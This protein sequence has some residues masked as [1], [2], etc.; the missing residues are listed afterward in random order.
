MVAP[1]GAVT[2]IATQSAARLRLLAR[3]NAAT[4]V[5]IVAAVAVIVEFEFELEHP[6]VLLPVGLLATK[7]AAAF[8]IPLQVAAI[9]GAR[10]VRGWRGL[11]EVRLGEMLLSREGK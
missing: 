1:S 2:A 4:L 9:E 5:S 11:A 6:A 7:A 10:P 3:L 8:L